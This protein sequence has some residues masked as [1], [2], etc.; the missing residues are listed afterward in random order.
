ML[1]TLAGETQSTREYSAPYEEKKKLTYED[2]ARLP[3]EPGFR[4]EVIDGV[5][6]REP[7]ASF[8]HQRVS[9]RPQHFNAA[10]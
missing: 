2:Y 8:R 7:Y 10:I 4:H 6:L 5:L 9:R 3:E 1:K